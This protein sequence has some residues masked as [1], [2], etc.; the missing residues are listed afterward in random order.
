MKI[1]RDVSFWWS[2][3]IHLPNTIV[4]RYISG[5]LHLSL[6][7]ACANGARG[8]LFWK[9]NNDVGSMPAVVN[10][11]WREKWREY[12]VLFLLHPSLSSH[13]DLSSKFCMLFLYFCYFFS[14]LFSYSSVNIYYSKFDYV[15]FWFLDLIIDEI[16]HKHR[17]QVSTT[18]ADL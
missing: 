3:F 15:N 18:K 14:G 10:F 6:S 13:P 4:H 16:T 7:L 17:K 11:A 1:L 2:P 8:C 9:R 12:L 5:I